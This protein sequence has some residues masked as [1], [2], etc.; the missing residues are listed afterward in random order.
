M[1]RLVLSMGAA[2]CREFVCNLPAEQQRHAR[3]R[4]LILVVRLARL[5][6]SAATIAFMAERSFAGRRAGVSLV[7]EAQVADQPSPR[8][9]QA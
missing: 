1:L 2:E 5:R 7:A 8:R 3:R 4:A 6:A 9:K